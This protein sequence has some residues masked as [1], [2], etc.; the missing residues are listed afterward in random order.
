L[1][2]THKFPQIRIETVIGIRFI[3]S[4]AINHPYAQMEV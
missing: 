2:S 1:T 4:G 3:Y